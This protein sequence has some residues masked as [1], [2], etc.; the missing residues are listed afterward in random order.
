M[1]LKN[2]KDMKDGWFVGAFEPSALNTYNCEVGV[3]YYIKGQVNLSH[4][5]K[6]ATE[7]TY[8]LYGTVIMN[9]IEFNKGDIV[10]VEPNEIV[11]FM[12]MSDAMLVIVKTPGA[13]NDKYNI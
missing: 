6:L 9:G 7:I 2:I 10:V 4:Y 3:K 8:V 11:D 5:H 13:L 1:I 12:A